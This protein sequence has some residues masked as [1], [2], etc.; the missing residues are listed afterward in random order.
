MDKKSENKNHSNTTEEKLN[1]LKGS[2]KGTLTRL[3]TLTSEKTVSKHT[4]ITE[5]EVN[6]KKIDQLQINLYKIAEDYCELETSENLETLKASAD[7][8]RAD[9]PDTADIISNDIYRA[10]VFSGESTLKGAKKLQIKVSHLFP[11]RVGF[12]LHKWVSNNPELLKDLSASSYVFDKECQD[13]PVK[14]L[15]MLY[16][17]DPKVDCLTYK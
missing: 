14:I 10:D 6:L 7:E 5:I 16:I 8:E 11:L 9:F 17:C 12:E 15:G 4:S 13:A 2:I 3:E 1:R